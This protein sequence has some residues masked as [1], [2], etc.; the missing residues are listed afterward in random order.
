MSSSKSNKQ[1]QR[2]RLEH[3]FNS[4]K[5]QNNQYDQSNLWNKNSLHLDWKFNLEK[6]FKSTKL[7]DFNILI[8]CYFLY[9]QSSFLIE[10]NIYFAIYNITFYFILH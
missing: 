1:M 6:K 4:L 2:S 10:L 3:L 5:C 9:T 8:A 7:C